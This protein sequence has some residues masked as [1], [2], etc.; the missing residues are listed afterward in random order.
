MDGLDILWA[1]I[2]TFIVGSGLNLYWDILKPMLAA[3]WSVKE[4]GI[5]WK[6]RSSLIAAGVAIWNMFVTAYKKGLL[7]AII[8]IIVKVIRAKLGV[9][10]AMR[11]AGMIK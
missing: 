2:G 6:L 5:A 9:P 11:K 8:S 3:I 10:T 1:A 4:D 7:D